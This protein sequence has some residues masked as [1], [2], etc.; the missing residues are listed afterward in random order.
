M[1][2]CVLL[3]VLHNLLPPDCRAASIHA[4]RFIS[5]T[6]LRITLQEGVLF[7][8]LLNRTKSENQLL[9]EMRDSGEEVEAKVRLWS[10]L[11]IREGVAVLS[12]GFSVC[13]SAGLNK[14][15]SD[16]AAG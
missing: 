12:H 13:K 10:A 14:M 7:E 9:Q 8:G 11:P 15:K 4:S 1:A 2:N 5:V 6:L 16:K 3:P